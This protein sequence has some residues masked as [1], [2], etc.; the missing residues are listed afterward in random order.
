MKLLSTIITLGILG[1]GLW[2]VDDHYPHLKTIAMEKI[3]TSN[4]LALEA[5]ITPQKLLADQKGSL[6][7]SNKATC[8]TPELR[9]APYLLLEVKYSKNSKETAESIMLW[10]LTDGEMI[11][12]TK[13]WE[14]T[15]GYGDC[16][17]AHAT[18]NDFQIIN[19]L[20]QNG[21]SADHKKLKSEITDQT[22]DTA[23]RKKLIV[24][25]DS[26]YRLHMKNPGFTADPKTNVTNPIVALSAKSGERLPKRYSLQQVKK[27]VEAAFVNDFVIKKATEIYVP[28]YAITVEESDNSLHTTF[29]N[30]LTGKPAPNSLTY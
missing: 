5:K 11:L 15:H 21:G 1:Y 7:K 25:T 2:W 23:L 22:I 26:G 24:Q 28:F 29:W 12:N 9:Y 19:V 14:K 17:E 16:I 20:A 30:A 8:H 6:T 18:P 3:G 27:N 10:D 13:T 4:V